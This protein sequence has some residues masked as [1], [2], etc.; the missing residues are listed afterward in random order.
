MFSII[1][2]KVIKPADFSDLDEQLA[3]RLGRFEQR[4]NLTARPFDWRFTS[5][6]L[7]AMLERLEVAPSHTAA[8][9]AT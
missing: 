7:A 2:H 8:P 9:L 1:Q 6:D 4:Y 3:D 5:E